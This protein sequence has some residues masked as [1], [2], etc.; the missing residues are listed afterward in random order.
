MCKLNV[1]SPAVRVCFDKWR[2]VI[3]SNALLH[4]ITFFLVYGHLLHTQISRYSIVSCFDGIPIFILPNSPSQPIGFD[5]IVSLS[6]VHIDE[7]GR[8]PHFR[9][10][11]IVPQEMRRWMM[12]TFCMTKRWWCV[13]NKEMYACIIQTNRSGKK[14][15]DSPLIL[16]QQRIMWGWRIIHNGGICD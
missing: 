1:F 16:R 4:L 10:G 2:W 11:I 5:W 12:S 6:S 8:R 14:L 15:M 7:G 9:T 3:R 13:K